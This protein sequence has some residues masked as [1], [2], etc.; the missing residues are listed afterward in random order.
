MKVEKPAV[1]NDL[2]RHARRCLA[3][4]VKVVLQDRLGDSATEALSA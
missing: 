2:I 4:D 1:A 3:R